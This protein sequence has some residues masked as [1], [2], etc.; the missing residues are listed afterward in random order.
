MFLPITASAQEISA[1]TCMISINAALAKE[2]R[3]YRYN[4]FGQKKA[5]HANIGSVYFD[6]DSYPWYKVAKDAW[7]STNFPDLEFSNGDMNANSE[8]PNANERGILETRRVLTSDLIPYLVSNMRAFQCNT[9]NICELVQQS[10]GQQQSE[11]VSVNIQAPGCIEIQET[12]TIPECHLLSVDT[13]QQL[14]HSTLAD[15]QQYCENTRIELLQREADLLKMIVEYDAAYRSLLQFAG[16]FDIFLEELRWTFTGTLKA[17]AKIIGSLGRIPCFIAAC[18]EPPYICGNDECEEDV[19]ESEGVCPADCEA[20]C[21]SGFCH[22]DE[23]C[24]SCP[25][26]CGPCSSP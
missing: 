24:N 12:N 2:N 10:L 3:Y 17:G 11:P 14:T 5:E 18:D 9:K 8:I 1:D 26:D 13:D 15:L 7:L 25:E 22:P 20:E 23:T 19:G 16:S 6:R 4:I 21:G